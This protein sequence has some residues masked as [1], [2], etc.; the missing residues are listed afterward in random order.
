MNYK[1]GNII[2]ST[3]TFY[4]NISLT[5]GATVFADMD[6]IVFLF[7]LD[8]RNVWATEESDA[9]SL[10]D[11]SMTGRLGILWNIVIIML[12]KLH[13]YSTIVDS[14]NK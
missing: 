9:D 11:N 10:Y 1:E 2:S 6:M 5:L 12:L 13:N 8:M 3:I 7:M 14:G 4:I